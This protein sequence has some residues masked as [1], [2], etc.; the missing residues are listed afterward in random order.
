MM[1]SQVKEWKQSKMGV[2]STVGVALLAQADCHVYLALPLVTPAS[3][4]AVF[5]RLGM[6]CKAKNHRRP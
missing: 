6:S 3:R 4:F 5:Q 1:F 2:V